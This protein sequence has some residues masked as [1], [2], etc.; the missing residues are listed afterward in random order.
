[1]QRGQEVGVMEYFGLTLLAFFILFLMLIVWIVRLVKEEDAPN[2]SWTNI[3]V[4]RREE[5]PDYGR[6]LLHGDII[7]DRRARNVLLT[8]IIK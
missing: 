2:T 7:S 5:L 1:M 6:V 8:A 4:D 3:S